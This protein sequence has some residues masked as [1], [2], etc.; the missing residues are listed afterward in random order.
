MNDSAITYTAVKGGRMASCECRMCRSKNDGITQTLQATGEW[1]PDLERLLEATGWTADDAGNRFCGKF[2][3]DK[4][5]Y[6]NLRRQ[7]VAAVTV[8]P[9]R[10]PGAAPMVQSN[11]PAAQMKTSADQPRGAK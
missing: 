2:C 4:W 10:R 8:L 6:S 11:G 7:T 9:G 1:L 5:A 3:R